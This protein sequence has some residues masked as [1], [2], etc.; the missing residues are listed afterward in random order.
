MKFKHYL[1]SI[2]SVS[3]YPMISL[4]LFLGFFIGVLIYVS[5]M[6][7]NQSDKFGKLPLN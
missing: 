7:K 1:S 2:D 5:K 4:M 3:I 6:S